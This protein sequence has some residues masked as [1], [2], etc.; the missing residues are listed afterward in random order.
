M[1]YYPSVQIAEIR[2]QPAFPSHGCALFSLPL[3]QQNT[4]DST[5][6][7][8]VCLLIVSVFSIDF[9]KIELGLPVAVSLLPEFLSGIA[10]L[11]ALRG[12][13]SNGLSLPPRYVVY[14][15]VL[16]LLVVFGLFV[17][18]ATSGPLVGGIRFYGK[19]IPFL[20]LP[21]VCEF[22]PTQL[23][24][25]LFLVLALAL[26]QFP[27][28]LLQ[29]FVLYF[30][31][32]GDNARGTLTS[33]SQTAIVL[34][35][36]ISVMA[37]AGLRRKI[38]APIVAVVCLLLFLPPTIAEVKGAFVLV[39]L[40]IGIPYFFSPKEYKSSKQTIT[41]FGS[42]AACLVVF[43]ALYYLAESTRDSK[44]GDA[45]NVSIVSFLTDPEKILRY[46]APQFVGAQ[47]TDRVGRWDAI[48]EPFQAF[49]EEPIRYFSGLG[50]GAL[51]ETPLDAFSADQYIDIRDGSTAV[52]ASILLWEFGLF[53]T[54]VI[55]FGLYMVWRDAVRLRTQDD[56]IG[57]LALGW[58]AIVP[59]LFI[60]LFWK[61][62]LSN[63]ALMSLIALLGGHLIA[64]AY[65]SSVVHFVESNDGLL[66]QTERNSDTQLPPLLNEVPAR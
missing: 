7:I 23:R 22:S 28:T 2:E 9:I 11:L 32:T 63:P 48:I 35:C 18:N 8:T 43:S 65:R 24:Q 13:L 46:M 10:F 53:G 50:M 6:H 12:F 19:Y 36:T 44:R 61:N 16:L 29:R 42:I 33:G 31:E 38:A 59:I 5:M 51:S 34:L 17:S 26:M 4:R 60:T 3:F 41:V 64:A 37:A 40:A 14:F 52:G 49:N 27:I 20:L 62:P 1:R 15:C 54:L 57:T 58:T 56:L 21:M 25:Q 66:R 47:G 30:G 45:H 55:L 39:P